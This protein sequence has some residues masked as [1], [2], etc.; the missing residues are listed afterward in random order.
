VIA[1][2]ERRL[3]S[4]RTTVVAATQKV[5]WFAT[6]EA[7]RAHGFFGSVWLRPTGDERR[8]LL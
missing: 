2:S 1:P 6:L 3:R 8:P 7:I 5:F 4:I